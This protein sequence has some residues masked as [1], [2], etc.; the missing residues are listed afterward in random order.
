MR[1]GNVDQLK[2][3]IV[4]ILVPVVCIVNANKE[5]PRRSTEN[6]K[7]LIR[8]GRIFVGPRTIILA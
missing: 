1:L 6:G 7:V 8:I 3:H 4:E 2:D 5:L